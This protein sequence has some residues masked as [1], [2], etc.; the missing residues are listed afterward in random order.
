M[1]RNIAMK[2]DSGNGKPQAWAVEAASLPLAFAQVREDP[3]LDL[4]LAA[5]L[6]VGAEVVMIAS[7]GDT[8]VCLA[9]LP[10]G[11]IHLVDMNAAQLALTRLKW[12]L[13]SGDGKEA[14]ALL[15]HK[16]LEPDLR[17]ER[18]QS[19]CGELG[20]QDA[21]FG[22][23]DFVAEYGPD[24]VGRYERTFAKLRESLSPWQEDLDRWL[25]SQEPE[26]AAAAVAEDAAFGV[27]IDE[28]F[29]QVMSLANLVQ[30]FGEGATRNPRREFHRHFAWRT[31][32]VVRRL[33]AA[34][35]PFLWQIFAGRFPEGVAYDGFMRAP[36]SLKAHPVYHHARMDE[37]LAGLPA[38][39]VDLVHLSNILDWLSPEEAAATLGHAARVLRPG[40]KVIVRQLNSTL[41][42]AGL[43]PAIV[44]DVPR[45]MA[46]EARDRSFF[47]PRIHVGSRA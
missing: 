11:T 34:T 17:K 28:A 3:R 4:E 6:P 13:A 16:F 33:P 42:F 27:A 32:E 1:A 41:E 47:Y 45:G 5:E 19:L 37:A 10:L 38:G 14:V 44:W 31:R 30:L 12:Q 8:A 25:K 40:G 20:L 2:D 36:M 7:G 9:E 39:S 23:I 46:M 26:V 24:H 35:N 43:E 22:P 21:V 18:L 29:A 15:G